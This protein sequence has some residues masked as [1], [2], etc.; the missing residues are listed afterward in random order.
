MLLDL[1]PAPDPTLRNETE[2]CVIASELLSQLCIA[3]KQIPSD[4]PLATAE[5]QLNEFLN[6]P[7]GIVHGTIVGNGLRM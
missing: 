4:N 3:I 7:A 2:A 5:N 6:D 1:S